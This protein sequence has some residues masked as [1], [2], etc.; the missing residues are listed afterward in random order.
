MNHVSHVDHLIYSKKPPSTL[1]DEDAWLEVEL[2]MD[3]LNHS[4]PAHAVVASIDDAN[5]EQRI[6]VQ[7]AVCSL[8]SF[9]R[10]L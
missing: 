8:R 10:N 4:L 1:S 6:S 3:R 7:Q 9:A 5:P 2:L